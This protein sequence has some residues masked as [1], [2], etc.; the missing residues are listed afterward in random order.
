M[1][2]SEQY[3]LKSKESQRKNSRGH[4]LCLSNVKSSRSGERREKGISLGTK[5][6]RAREKEKEQEASEKREMPA[7]K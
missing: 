1:F 5:S 7:H 3:F 2:A 4:I 6:G